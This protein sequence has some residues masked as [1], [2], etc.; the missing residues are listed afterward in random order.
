MGLLTEGES[1]SLTLWPAFGTFF[2]LNIGLTSLSSVSGI[3]P[4]RVSLV[5]LCFF[6]MSLGHLLFSEGKW[7]GCGCG[8]KIEGEQLEGKGEGEKCV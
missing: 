5:L 2:F 4:C 8:R 3:L 1:T 7:R 6:L